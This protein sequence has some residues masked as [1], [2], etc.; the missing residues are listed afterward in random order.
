MVFKSKGSRA[1][2]TEGWTHEKTKRIAQDS[3]WKIGERDGG[4]QKDTKGERGREQE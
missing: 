1:R 2:A 4:R 3:A